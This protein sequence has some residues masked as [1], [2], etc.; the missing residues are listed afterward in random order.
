MIDMPA[1]CAILR[2][3]RRRRRMTQ[4]QLAHQIGYDSVSRMN[5]VE[6]GLARPATQR[7]ITWA[8]S[9]GHQV[10]AI[11]ADAT[12][13]PIDHPQDLV[14]LLRAWREQR[15]WSRST[16]ADSASTRHACIRA[17]ERGSPQPGL[18]RL[19]R[20]LTVFGA[21]LDVRRDA[22]A[23]SVPVPAGLHPLVAELKAER[24]RRELSQKTIAQRSGVSVTR[25]EYAERGRS[26]PSLD[27]LIFW[28]GALD[29]QLV[30]TTASGGVH[31]VTDPRMLG[32]LLRAERKARGH[33]VQKLTTL[34]RLAHGSLTDWERNGMTPRLAQA[35]RW[36]A[37]LGATLTLTPTADIPAPTASTS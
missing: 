28:A 26:L 3:E 2:Q 14:L 24:V 29:H 6:R 16:V 9:L 12:V 23:V 30:A 25:L 37:A 18:D 20:W 19:G 22:T 13:N 35:G 27:T 33:T 17:W 15:G 1:I 32:P 34:A 21:R 7:L 4:A 36:T 10:I 31:A 8:G 5:Q 11:A